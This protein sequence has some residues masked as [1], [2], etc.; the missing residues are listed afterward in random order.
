MT[1]LQQPPFHH[2]ITRLPS[3]LH[4]QGV[5]HIGIVNAREQALLRWLDVALAHFSP[6]QLTEFLQEKC[7]GVW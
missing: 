7:T 4:H 1:P 2:P 5:L 3:L 6:G